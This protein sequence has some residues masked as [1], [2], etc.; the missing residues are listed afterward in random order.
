[1][2][3]FLTYSLATAGYDAALNP[4]VILQIATDWNTQP[5][6]GVR[7]SSTACSESE[8]PVFSRL[9]RGTM[10][11]YVVKDGSQRYFLQEKVHYETSNRKNSILEEEKPIAA[12]PSVLQS[13]FFG[14]YV[15]GTRGGA[16]FAEAIRPDTSGNCPSGTQVCSSKTS[17]E[18]TLC[19]A[20]LDDCPVTSITFVKGATSAYTAPTFK[21]EAFA[22]SYSLVSSKTDADQL[23]VVATKAE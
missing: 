17:K 20:D 12:S 23:P 2:L 6:V 21:V 4:S 11:G 19:V 16:T 3:G 10:D 1:M 13:Q 5:F 14:K 9:W 8:V 15:C 22:E 7:V 18:N